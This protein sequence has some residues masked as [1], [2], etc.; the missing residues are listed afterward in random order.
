SLSFWGG[1]A[2]IATSGNAR[3]GLPL[4]LAAA[5]MAAPV[6]WHGMRSPRIW[7]EQTAPL[8]RGAEWSM[9]EVLHFFVT[10]LFLAWAL[11]RQAPAYF[12][13]KR[14]LA[15][16][17]VAVPYVIAG[18]AGRRPAFALVAAAAFATAAILHWHNVTAVLVL[19]ALAAIWAAADHVF[20]RSDGRW[21]AVPTLIAALMHLLMYDA[22]RRGAVSPAFVDP[23]ALALW[24]ALALTVILAM[25]L[26]RPAGAERD[27]RA[28]RTVLWVGAGVLLLFGV[29]AEIQRYF[30]QHTARLAAAR[31]AGG[32]A[33]SAWWLAFATA[34]V[35]FG[36]R[37]GSQ[38]VRQFG[39]GVA[40]LAVAKVLLVDLSSLDALYRVGSVF[41][42]G[43]MSLLVAY[44]YHRH[45]QELA[46]ASRPP[47]TTEE[48]P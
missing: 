43:L 42:L 6:W 25:G 15:A 16:L 38:P 28:M 7:P 45:A 10:P 11:H 37:R 48:R 29:T 20:E 47:D 46:A 31:L 4:L 2:L 23:W 40:A 9:G 12:D 34:L 44:R 1:W 27:V 22:L 8:L 30:V 5:I 33:V 18:Y 3:A 17:V 26:W 14:G 36:F 13:A 24:M 35:L 41:I 32:L 19:V 21:Y 39:L